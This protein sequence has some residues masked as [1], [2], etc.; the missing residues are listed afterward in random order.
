MSGSICDS[1]ANCVYDDDEEDYF[2]N[3]E[4]DEDE[5][6]RFYTSPENMCPYYRRDDEYAVVRHQM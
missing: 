2:C 4:M 3:V 5:A 1:C 6:V